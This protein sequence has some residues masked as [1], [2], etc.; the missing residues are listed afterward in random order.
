MERICATVFWIL[1]LTTMS[2]PYLSLKS[3]GSQGVE[4]SSVAKNTT[5][6]TFAFMVNRYS[7]KDSSCPCKCHIGA[8][9]RPHMI[10][11]KLFGSIFACYSGLPFLN[12]PCDVTL[13]PKKCRKSFDLMYTFPSWF[14]QWAIYTQISISAHG[15]PS[16]GIN[17]MRR[18]P[19]TEYSIFAIAR[20][21]E[22]QR[23][24]QILQT[25]SGFSGDLEVK[26]GRNALFWAIHS[27]SIETVSSLLDYGADPLKTDDTGISPSTYTYY[28]SLTGYLDPQIL[29]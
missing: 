4:M 15:E 6:T 7:N 17:F 25:Q 23:L 9:F 28:L 26:S 20:R 2:D 3:E 29:A 27:E 19:V 24:R 21:S 22:H 1:P 11:A 13:C 18:S 5:S 10:S 8:R 14:I 12:G 16:F